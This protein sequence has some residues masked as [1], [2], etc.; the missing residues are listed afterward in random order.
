MVLVTSNCY[1][2]NSDNCFDL[3]EKNYKSSQFVQ[4]PAVSN[5]DE[6]MELQQNISYTA[7]TFSNDKDKQQHKYVCSKAVL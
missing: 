2:Y 4:H 1:Y 3:V 7:S 6:Q 5:G